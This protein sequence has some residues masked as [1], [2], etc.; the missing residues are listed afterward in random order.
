MPPP[1]MPIHPQGL[2]TGHLLPPAGELLPLLAAAEAA[3][4]AAPVR[5]SSRRSAAVAARSQRDAAPAAAGALTVRLA[6]EW[7]QRIVEEMEARLQLQEHMLDEGLG[8]QHLPVAG[9]LDSD[10]EQEEEEEVE[11]CKD[12]DE[13]EGTA[14]LA[15]QLGMDYGSEGESGE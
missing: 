15:E 2:Q 13:E 11:H 9:D 3:A 1:V 5:R 10:G 12:W 4:P 8:A 7:A 14:L 6:A